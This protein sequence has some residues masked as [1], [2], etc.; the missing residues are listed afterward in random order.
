MD[1]LQVLQSASTIVR[2]ADEHLVYVNGHLSTDKVYNSVFIFLCEV[3]IL[4]YKIIMR[5]S[6]QAN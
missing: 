1:A 5:Y 2:D 6:S 3:H 4:L